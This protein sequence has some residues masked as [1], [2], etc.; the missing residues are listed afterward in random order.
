MTQEITNE[1]NSDTF[2]QWS[3]ETLNEFAEQSQDSQE[4]MQ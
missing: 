4:R 1:G 2:N 3:H